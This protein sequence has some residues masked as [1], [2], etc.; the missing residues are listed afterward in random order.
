MCV[1]IRPQPILEPRP[2]HRTGSACPQR[3]L[4]VQT[5]TATMRHLKREQG[6][7][8]PRMVHPR[9][10]FIPPRGR[11]GRRPHRLLG[12]RSSGPNSR[13][14]QHHPKPRERPSVTLYGPPEVARGLLLPGLQNRVVAATLGLLSAL[15]P[16][17]RPAS[18]IWVDNYARESPSAGDK[19][20][21][22]PACLRVITPSL[23]PR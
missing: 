17:R 3:T 21:Y 8:W 12:R 13:R 6:G 4:P 2:R 11:P 15:L 22:S 14:H 16:D 1:S 23:A 10:A 20:R 18:R 7:S 5:A 19:R 9:G